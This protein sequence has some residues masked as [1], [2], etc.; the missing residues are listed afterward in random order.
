MPSG[1]STGDITLLLANNKT[2]QLYSIF[3]FPNATFKLLKIS[4]SSYTLSLV[5]SLWHSKYLYKY[6]YNDHAKCY[7]LIK[8]HKFKIYKNLQH[9]PFFSPEI[10]HSK[11]YTK[12]P[13]VIVV[14]WQWPTH[15]WN[16]YKVLWEWYRNSL[17][18]QT[19]ISYPSNQSIAILYVQCTTGNNHSQ[20][21]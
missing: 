2:S 3:N 12:S 11:S 16:S 10:D 15:H 1:L 9:L 8:N 4:R 19:S 20:I 18:L 6:W 14:L 7:P 17:S 13:N 5:L 21:R